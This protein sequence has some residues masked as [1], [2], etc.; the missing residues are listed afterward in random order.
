M[1]AEQLDQKNSWRGA[2]GP[3]P[4]SP[5]SIAFLGKDMAQSNGTRVPFVRDD[6][7]RVGWVG[8]GLRLIPRTA[9][10]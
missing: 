8:S 6:A 3:S 9:A 5:T 4:P 10:S 1:K 2:I 7:G